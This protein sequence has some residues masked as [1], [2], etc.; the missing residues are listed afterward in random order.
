MPKHTQQLRIDQPPFDPNAPASGGATD[1]IT[2][3]APPAMGPIEAPY[4]LLLATVL[5]RSS[6]SPTAI[7]NATWTA[8]DGFDSSTRS[9]TLSYLIQWS[10]DPTFAAPAGAQAAMQAS[11]AIDGLTT[12]TTYYFRVAAVY[13]TV[14]S[15]FSTAASIVTA[16]DTVPPAPVTSAA[17]SFVGTGDLVVTWV[18]PTSENYKDVEVR[19]Y[20]SNG[21]AL[22]ATLYSATSTL[23]WS[24]AQNLAATSQVGDP[25]LYLDIRARSWGNVYSTSVNLSPVK[26][27]PTAPTVTVDFTGVDAVYTITPPT[28]A[29]Y[30]NFVA[31]TGV[32]AR[33]L[34]VIGR[35][36]YP[37][38]QNRL[39]HSGTPDPSL[40]YSFTAVDGLNQA[41]AATAGTATNAAPA[42][43]TV[44]LIGGFSALVCQVT[45]SPAVD[46]SSYEFVWKRDG[47]T[48]LTLESASAEQQYAT[49]AAGDEGAHSWTCTVRQKDMFAQY[50]TA[51]AS[52]AV[53]LDTL[54]IGYLRSGA[55]YSDD[56]GGTFT[57]PASGT[58][59]AMKDDIKNAGGISYAA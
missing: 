18:N 43:P 52:S 8:P 30:I 54:T 41:S 50:S 6:A 46:F 40:A 20:A 58:L 27:A 4:D 29:L 23:F 3:P 32:T 38:D 44:T 12:G 47:G 57:P 28:D 49:G 1:T 26:S 14:Q 34:G 5:S 51:T 39:D 19:I 37:F 13:S 25:S 11:A 53:V 15:P 48:V 36:V 24:A 10:T 59:A 16:I 9:T 45:S 21:G 56:A 55:F 42:A 33:R 2:D 31:D 22:L 35:Y 7:V 17:A